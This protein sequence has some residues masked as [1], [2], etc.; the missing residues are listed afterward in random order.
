MHV[1]YGF[2]RKINRV[3]V[4]CL[5]QNAEFVVTD[6]SYPKLIRKE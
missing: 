5:I 4:C 3:E 2:E 6:E 1:F